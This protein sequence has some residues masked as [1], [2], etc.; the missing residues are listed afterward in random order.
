MYMYED[1][2]NMNS[3]TKS[4]AQCGIVYDGL[5]NCG[6]EHWYTVVPLL[7]ATLNRGHPLIWP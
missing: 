6:N 2:T 3:I 7:L 1:Q 4:L 5:Y